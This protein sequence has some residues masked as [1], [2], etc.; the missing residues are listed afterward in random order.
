MQPSEDCSLNEDFIIPIPSLPSSSTSTVYV[1]FSRPR[2]ST[3]SSSYPVGSFPCT[4]RFVSKEV[5]PTSGE[6]EEDGYSDEY[7]IEELELGAADYVVPSYATFNSEW[8]RLGSGSDETR[9]T[10]VFAL[11]SSASLKAACDSLIEGTYL[12]LLSAFPLLK[13]RKR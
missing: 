12:L 6:P 9:A 8:E 11:S 4:L 5:D 2:T 1:S 13:R 3:S 10:E 7:Q